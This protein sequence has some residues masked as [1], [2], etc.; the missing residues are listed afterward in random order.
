MLSGN[1][2][3]LF[4]R[5]SMQFNLTW[6]PSETST[7]GSVT[8]TPTRLHKR[9]MTLFEFLLMTE[10]S[11]SFFEFGSLDTNGSTQGVDLPLFQKVLT[12]GIDQKLPP[13]NRTSNADCMKPDQKLE[14]THTRKLVLSYK[15]FQTRTTRTSPGPNPSQIVS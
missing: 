10:F 12:G 14:C 9:L 2:E 6:L 8:R 11:S 15:L 7:E 3:F 13:P 1:E 4:V 5:Q